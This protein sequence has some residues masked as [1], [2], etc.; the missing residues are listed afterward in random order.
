VAPCTDSP[1]A[2][3]LC[4]NIM[5]GSVA[6]VV[7]CSDQSSATGITCSASML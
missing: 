1:T 2:S 4:E 3:C 5:L 7:Q 6:P